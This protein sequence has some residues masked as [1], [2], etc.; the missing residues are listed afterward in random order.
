MYSN[1]QLY[2]LMWPISNPIDIFSSIYEGQRNTGYLPGVQGAISNRQTWSNHV[3]IADGFNLSGGNIVLDKKWFFSNIESTLF[4][5]GY[6]RYIHCHPIRLT[7]PPLT[8]LV[9]IQQ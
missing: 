2:G 3:R 9:D 4:S 6:S 7:S 8:P 5:S 1:S